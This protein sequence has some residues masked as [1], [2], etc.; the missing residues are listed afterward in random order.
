MYGHI[1][2]RHVQASSNDTT[3]PMARE[4]AESDADPKRQERINEEGLH[5]VIPEIVEQFGPWMLAKQ[6]FAVFLLLKALRISLRIGIWSTPREI[7][8][9]LPKREDNPGG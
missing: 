3:P 1:E 6:K 7:G 4:E 5:G 9:A 8:P 2:E